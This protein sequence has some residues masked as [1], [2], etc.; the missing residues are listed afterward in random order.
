[1]CVCVGCMLSCSFMSDSL[2]SHELQATGL[3]CPWDFPGKNSRVGCHALL[4]G[5]FPTQGSN[6]CLLGLYLSGKPKF[7]ITDL[8]DIYTTGVQQQTRGGKKRPMNFKREQWA[9]PIRAVKMNEK[10][11]KISLR[12]L[13]DNIKQTNTGIMGSQKEE[14]KKK[15]RK[16]I[17]KNNGWKLP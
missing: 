15:C 4:Q 7:R 6:S 11:V 16:L 10:K 17:W 5:I 3:L 8:K 2:W 13:K 14:R 1:M 9:Y 12:N